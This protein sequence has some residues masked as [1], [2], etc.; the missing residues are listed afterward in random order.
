MFRSRIPQL[1]RQM[2]I[3]FL[4]MPS[5]VFW[6]SGLLKDSITFAMVALFT[7]QFLSF[8]E[9]R[10]TLG[11]IFFTSLISFISDQDQTLHFLL[12]CC[13][14]LI[15]LAG[16]FSTFQ[17]D[18][19]AGPRINRSDPGSHFRS[20]R[21]FHAG[22]MGETLG[23]YS[24]NRVIDKAFVTNQDLKA[25]LLS[26]RFFDIGDFDPTILGMIGKAPAAI[27]AALFRPYLWESPTVRV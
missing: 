15:P 3:A 1:Q 24:V 23:E 16:W 8:D 22:V 25:G 5:V 13:L 9:N 27:N 26:G 20:F 19:S 7:S 4:F 14:V 18:Q 11:R 2:V 6:G 21:I 10:H 17:D 12:Q